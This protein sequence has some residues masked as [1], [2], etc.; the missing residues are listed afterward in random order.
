MKTL[1]FSIPPPNMGSAARSALGCDA[2]AGGDCEHPHMVI[3]CTAMVGRLIVEGPAL[4]AFKLDN[5][6]FH[7]TAFHD[8]DR[9]E[10]LI[11]SSV[12]TN[13]ADPFVCP[14]GLAFFNDIRVEFATIGIEQLARLGNPGLAG[15]Y[16]G[17]PFGGLHDL[18]GH[19][20]PVVE[21]TI[22]ASGRKKNNRDRHHVS[23]GLSAH[24]APPVSFA[25]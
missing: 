11:E 22:G 5:I 7:E 14:A 23:Q 3:S 8:V 10:M 9:G 18:A 4:S 6:V 17:P 21:G 19:E 25:Y 13:L 2:A 12:D 15:A 1:A 24:Y 16:N 20:M